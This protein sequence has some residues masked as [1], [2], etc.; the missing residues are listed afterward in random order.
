M[1]LPTLDSDDLFIV[2]R[3]VS[4]PLVAL[5]CYFAAGMG[6]VG[7]TFT[8][9]FF[10]L[11]MSLG[12]RFSFRRLEPEPDGCVVIG[13][14][15]PV[16]RSAL[17]KESLVPQ[18]RELKLA[19]THRAALRPLRFILLR[20]LREAFPPL[21]QH[22]VVPC[23]MALLAIALGEVSVL[24]YYHVPAWGW[25]VALGAILMTGIGLSRKLVSDYLVGRQRHRKPRLPAPED[26]S[27]AHL[28]EQ[29]RERNDALMR[30]FGFKPEMFVSGGSLPEELVRDGLPIVDAK[31]SSL[32]SK[33]R[34]AHETYL[35]AIQDQDANKKHVDLFEAFSDKRSLYDFAQQL[36][37]QARFRISE[38]TWE[39]RSAGPV[40]QDDTNGSQ[41]AS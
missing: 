27:I 38:C 33:A 16:S 5:C 24:A 34:R 7:A 23:G 17:L 1:K 41:H 22:V 19:R 31:L 4:M 37:I 40:V 28:E 35:D 18:F 11:C 6:W 36:A 20:L 15:K 2:I 30:V 25:Y 13:K 14:D 29:Q 39:Q 10:A 3:M 26:D 32:A 8:V 21:M 9:A 12:A